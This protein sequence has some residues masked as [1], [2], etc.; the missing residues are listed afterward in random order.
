[1]PLEKWQDYDAELQMW[2]KAAGVYSNLTVRVRGPDA[3]G[4]AP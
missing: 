1:M 4:S 2:S 3:G